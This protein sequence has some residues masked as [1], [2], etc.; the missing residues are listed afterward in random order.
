[1]GISMSVEEFYRNDDAF[2]YSE[3]DKSFGSTIL[4]IKVLVQVTLI[5]FCSLS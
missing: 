4:L 3:L 2:V 5:E 1:M